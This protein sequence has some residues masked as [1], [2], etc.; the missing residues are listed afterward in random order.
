MEVQKMRKKKYKQKEG[1][2]Y[3]KTS[4]IQIFWNK[5]NMN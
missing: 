5:Y 4:I 2:Y 3:L 1:K